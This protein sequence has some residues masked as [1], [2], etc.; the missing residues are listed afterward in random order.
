[1]PEE[2][3]QKKKR[4]HG[5][6]KVYLAK[7]IIKIVIV[8]VIIAALIFGVSRYFSTGTKTTTIGFENIGELATQAAY[9]T[10]VNVTEASRELFGLSIPFTQSKYIYSYDVEI[11]AGMD[12]GEIV[13]QLNDHTI[14]VSLPET[15]V[16]STQIDLDSF[17]VY[18]EDESIF[19]EITLEEN[20][21]A[22][23]STGKS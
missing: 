22:L 9:S 15:K 2:K 18:L 7:N 17:E 16:L 11:K 20:N 10:E 5:V 14:E 21:E 13:W 23:N 19:R 8:L 6:L 4:E 3:I 12:F 1:M